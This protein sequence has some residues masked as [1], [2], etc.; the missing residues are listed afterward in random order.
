MGISANRALK[1]H[2]GL[3]VYKSFYSPVLFVGLKTYDKHV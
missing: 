3:G 2:I 1:K